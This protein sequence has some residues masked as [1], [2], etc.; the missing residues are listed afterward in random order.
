MKEQ[1]ESV[2]NGFRCTRVKGHFGT[3]RYLGRG[4]QER[5]DGS[6]SMTCLEWNDKHEVP[7]YREFGEAF[8]VDYDLGE[9]ERMAAFSAAVA[10]A[11]AQ[12]P[13]GTV[14]EVRAKNYPKDGGVVNDFGRTPTYNSRRDMAKTWG[15]AWYHTPEPPEGFPRRMSYSPLVTCSDTSKG[16]VKYEGGYVLL[17]RMEA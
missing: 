8:P 13:K 1:C 16:E 9:D 11:R 14:F 12:L 7:D 3:H 5:N 6:L 15:I 2:Y 17:A 4:F 10:D